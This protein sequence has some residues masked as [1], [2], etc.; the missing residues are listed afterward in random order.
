MGRVITIL[1]F[2]ILPAILLL[3]IIVSAVQVVNVWMTNLSDDN[4][5]ESRQADYIGTATAIAPSD[6]ARNDYF[7][8]A[9]FATNTPNADTNSVPSNT[10][11]PTSEPAT[12]APA[13][14]TPIVLPTFVGVQDPSIQIIA[15]TA[16]PPRASVIPRT[17]ELVNIVLLGSDGDI[18]GDNTIRTDTIVIVSINTQ[19]QTV[20]MLSIPRDVFVYVPTP[21][22]ARINTVYGTGE[23][24]GWSGGGFGLLRETIFY[25]FG[26]QVHYHAFVDISGLE[27]IIDTVGGIN[28]AVDCDYE[29]P[30]L[31][32]ADVPAGAIGPDENNVYVLPVGYY[33]FTGREAMWF[34]RSRGNSDAFDRGRRH[35]QVL[36]AILR[37]ARD[38]GQIA[39]IPELWAE[40]TQIVETDIT[41]DVVLGLLPIAVNLD[42]SRIER[43]NLVR[44]YHTQPWTPS[45]G[46]YAGQNVQ[47]LLAEPLNA[48]MTDFYTPPPASRLSLA[49]ASIAVYNG[50]DRPNLDIVASER[51]RNAGLNAIALGDAEE[52][53]VVN[54]SLID[55]AAQSRGS[56]S[57]IISSELNITG[58]NVTTSPDPNR[59]YDYV[60]V[61]GE[62]YNS[63]AGNVLP[64]GS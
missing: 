32:G 23:A 24:F 44:T 3:A 57:P 62:T 6:D 33:Q 40:L 15:G 58:D 27:E 35:L 17:D 63:C 42:S 16:V 36:E 56:A 7:H 59:E 18:V 64:V 9:Q 1:F 21:T 14:S 31:I 41:L 45:E 10:P 54:T 20:S 48:L 11:E 26:I 2:R 8:F 43:F 39:Q 49:G 55:F 50:T 60:V 53:G 30:P 12:E 19:T 46:A 5:T 51:L 47:L 29:D 4:Q 22:M 61:V 37:S 52:T 28:I 25:N 34:A 38:S 13:Q